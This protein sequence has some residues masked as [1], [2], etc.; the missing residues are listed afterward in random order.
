MRDT[1]AAAAADVVEPVIFRTTTKKSP[2]TPSA[3][4]E[5]QADDE[6]QVEP[7]GHEVLRRGRELVEARLEER[8]VLETDQHLRAEHEHTRIV[9]RVLYLVFKFRHVNPLARARRGAS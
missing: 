8:A 5:P 4:R 9:E 2:A 7:D 6:Q 1:R 3:G